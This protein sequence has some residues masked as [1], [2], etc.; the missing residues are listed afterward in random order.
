MRVAVVGASGYTG[1]ELLR[2][3]LRHPQ[4]EV[5]AVTSEQ[6]AGLAVG[7]AFPSLRGLLDLRFES[8]AE[9]TSIA[10]R[11]DLAFTALPHAASAP[12][13]A[14]LRKAGVAVVDLSADFRLRDA[15]VYARW[16]GEHKA[17]ELLGSAVYGLPEL[18]REAIRKAD[19]VAAPGCYPTSLLVPLAP[20]LRAGL[21][22]PEHVLADS[23][24][25]VSGAG[26]TLQD[27]YLF[28]ELD[29]NV[30][31]YKVGGTHRHVAEMEQEASALA[32]A[33]VRIAFVPHLL[34]TVRGMA[35]TLFLRPRKALTTDDALAVLHAAYASEPFVR[36]LPAGETPRI[37][38][39]RGSNFLDVGA[40]VDER[41]GA[42]VLLS[43]L[44]NLGKG[45]SGQAVQC[46]NLMKGLP[47]TAGLLEAPLVP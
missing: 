30:H 42:L 43:T 40:V 38:S 24:S 44:D 11:A 28:A 32:K 4:A 13:V 25:G 14:A 23:K 16:Y 10:S 7:E 17:P 2:I 26:R 34:P 18:H 9:A 41:T 22:E 29:G 39:V 1:L 6:R 36:V 20:F 31:A 21:V 27:G 45:A 19:F 37:A 12:V 8:A 35:T 15:A 46:M 47:E 33:A 5:V 3:L